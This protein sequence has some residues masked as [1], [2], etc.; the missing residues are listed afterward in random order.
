MA[1]LYDIL[2]GLGV[3]IG[4]PYWLLKPAARRK[5]AEAFSQRMGR[6]GRRESGGAAIMIHAVSLGEVNAAREL[7]GQLRERRPDLH[8]IISTTTHAGWDRAVQLFEKQRGQGKITL[9]RYPLD[10][11][12]AVNRILDGLS[13]SLVVLMELELWPNFMRQCEARGIPVVLVNGRVTELSFRRYRR[14]GLITRRMFGRL[15]AACVQ[16]EAYAERF[17]ALG[18]ARERISVTGTMKFDTA[19]LGVRVEGDE[20]LA[21]ELELVAGALHPADPDAQRLWVCGSTGP[22]EEEI[23]LGAYRR[24]LGKFGDLRLAIVPRKPER[25]DEVAELIR[26]SGFDLVRRSGGSAGASRSAV[27]L[28]D[29]MGELRKF[30][31]LADVVFVGR[32]LVDLGP[33]QHGSDM[34]EPAALGKNVIVGPF[35]ANFAE[36]MLKF[37]TE[38][39]M[40]EVDSPD[41]LYEAVGGLLSSATIHMG[42]KARDIVARERGATARHVDS[43]LRHLGPARRKLQDK[44]A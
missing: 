21:N 37:R 17:V 3:G 44:P 32:T 5:V 11:S 43:I 27:I 20:A 22:G 42:Q 40:I 28:G 34:I 13:P 36:V 33:R 2:Y 38:R 10:F 35:T 24:L 6:V 1:N 19:T 31:S 41:G 12:R 4:A 23:V 29:T 18:V 15:A 9:I 16:D 14:A 8:C 39:A 26:S 30:Y 7:I 25:F